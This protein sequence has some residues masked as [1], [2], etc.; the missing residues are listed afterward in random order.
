[1]DVLTQHQ[2]E[3]LKV[4]NEIRTLLMRM[5]LLKTRDVLASDDLYPQNTSPDLH[6]NRQSTASPC[7]RKPHRSH[8]LHYRSSSAGRN[9]NRGSSGEKSHQS[10]NDSSGT[11][12]GKYPL[13]RTNLPLRVNN[14]TS[15]NISNIHVIV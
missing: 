5:D 3:E 9:R 8:S 15:F 1:M 2:I 7:R 13:S 11:T 10:H 4:L 6:N 12:S 14:E